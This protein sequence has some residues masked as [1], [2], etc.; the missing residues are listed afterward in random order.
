M[1]EDN[2]LKYALIVRKF[3]LSNSIFIYRPERVVLGR[4]EE[5]RLYREHGNK[6]YDCIKDE[7]F[8]Y[9]NEDEGYYE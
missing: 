4:I 5:G 7:Y 6:S 1:E 9:S 8:N 2:K 3:E